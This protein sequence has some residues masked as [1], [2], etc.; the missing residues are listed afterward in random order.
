[1]LY[2]SEVMHKRFDAFSYR[3]AY[4]VLSILVDIDRVERQA[5]ALRFF[6][7]NRLN[8]FSFFTRDHGPQDG[9]SLRAWVDSAL[10]KQGVRLQGGRVQL[11]CF[12]RIL[13]YAFNPL[14]VWFCEHRDGSLRAILCEVKNT[15]GEQHVYVLHDSGRVLTWPMQACV[16]KH[17]HVS[18][19]ISM[20]ASYKFSFTRPG[21]DVAFGIRQY[22][23]E[24]LLLVATFCGRRATLSDRSLL[25]G[26]CLYP[27]M[28]VKVLAMIHWQ[29]MLLYLRGAP[30]F[31][32]PP[33]PADPIS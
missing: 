27:L 10:A 22:Q 28:S 24:R 7:Y 25:R 20:D 12:P 3:F 26:F 23:G 4:R 13:G 21:E 9:S 1:M 19:F 33:P 18:P 5:R 32:K 8:L 15:F 16:D 6:S 14:S 31:K 30:F 17:F 11:L 2:F 29:A